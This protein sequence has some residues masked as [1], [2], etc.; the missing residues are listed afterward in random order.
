MTLGFKL[1][2]SSSRANL[3]PPSSSLDRKD[4]THSIETKGLAFFPNKLNLF[5]ILWFLFLSFFPFFFFL[6]F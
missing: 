2:W 1:K 5:E 3:N 4:I 6:A